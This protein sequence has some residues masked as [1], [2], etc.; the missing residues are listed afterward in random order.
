MCRAFAGPQRR[1]AVMGSKNFNFWGHLFTSGDENTPKIRPFKFKD[2][3]QRLPKQLENNFEIAQ[4]A[5]FRPPKL[6]NITLS[7]VKNESTVSQNAENHKKSP[8]EKI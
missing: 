3:A 6:S 2:N 4:N 5:I 8:N 7:K 1:A